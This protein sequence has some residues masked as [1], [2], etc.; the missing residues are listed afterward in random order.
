MRKSR[1]GGAKGYIGNLLDFWLV[2]FEIDVVSGCNI[3]FLLFKNQTLICH[4]CF[5]LILIC[6]VL[7]YY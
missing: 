2:G 7:R 6:L 1:E 4:L 3:F 5:V